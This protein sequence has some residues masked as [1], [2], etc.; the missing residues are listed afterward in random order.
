MAETHP[1]NSDAERFRSELDK[2][3][4]APLISYFLRRVGNRAEAEDL[5]QEVFVRMLRHSDGIEPSRAKAYIFSA[6]GNLLRDRARRAVT[7]HTKAHHPL[8]GDVTEGENAE[9]REEI[10]P[11]R[12]IMGRETLRDVLLALDSLNQR[13]RDIFVLY[14][15]ER[16]KLH[17]IAA[18]YGLSQGAIAKH[19]VKAMDHLNERFER[20]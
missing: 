17:E 2:N 19:L 3:F 10:S 15:I 13:T 4:R 1:L 16:M 11:E 14:R 5:T 18:L 8:G 6:A 9:M 20:P 12:V 7:H